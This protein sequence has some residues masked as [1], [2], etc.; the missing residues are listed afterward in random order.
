MKRTL[1]VF[2]VV[3]S[4]IVVTSCSHPA[5]PVQFP[6]PDGHTKWVSSVIKEI[7]TIKV[8]M[9]RKQ[10]LEV[11]ATEGGLSTS[12]QQTYV[13]RGCPNIK[14]D[15]KFKIVGERDISPAGHRFGTGPSDVIQDI[16]KPYLQWSIMD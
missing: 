6:S 3:T 12:T 4:I 10:L 5:K 16:S 7:A 9:T 13:Y 15:V 8:G 1:L 11:F 2:A 14:V